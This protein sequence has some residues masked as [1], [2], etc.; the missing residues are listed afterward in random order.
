MVAFSF[1]YYNPLLL[2]RCNSQTLWIN[3]S[4][5]MPL[6]PL[7]PMCTSEANTYLVLIIVSSASWT[8]ILLIR[9]LGICHHIL[10]FISLPSNFLS[11]FS[12]SSCVGYVHLRRTMSLPLV[13][14]KRRE[15]HTNRQ[16]NTAV[17]SCFFDVL[18]YCRH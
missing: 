2:T 9:F 7:H 17:A 4:R 15:I 3:L 14:L 13:M 18:S 12:P 1:V 16:Q 11:S 5:H 8:F 10:I 6:V